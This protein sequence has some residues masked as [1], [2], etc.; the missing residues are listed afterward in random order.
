M[1]DAFLAQG[2]ESEVNLAG[3]PVHLVTG[4]ELQIDSALARLC[5]PRSGADSAAIAAA[6]ARA[7]QERGRLLQARRTRSTTAD[8]KAHFVFDSVAP[9][10]YRI[11]ADT[12]VGGDRWTWLA[13]V[14]VRGG[15]TVRADLT[16]ANPDENPFRCRA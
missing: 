13:D 1:G 4:D 2:L 11:W 9:G 16:N 15:D 7:W 8:A 14:R 12:T 3:M 5:P 10:E 6:H